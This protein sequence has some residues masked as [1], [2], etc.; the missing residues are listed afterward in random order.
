MWP[1]KNFYMG[2]SK[3]AMRGCCTS[4]N[5]MVLL[6]VPYTTKKIFQI[7]SV[8]YTHMTA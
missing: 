7:K 5:H 2:I 1:L 4:E 3:S 8:V 6:S